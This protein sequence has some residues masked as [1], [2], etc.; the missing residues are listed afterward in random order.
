MNMRMAFYAFATCLSLAT[1]AQAEQRLKGALVP[2]E[3]TTLPPQ[4]VAQAAPPQQQVQQTPQAPAS[5]SDL[6]NMYQGYKADTQTALDRPH[7]SHA[8]L[9]RWLTE[10]LAALF[11]FTPGQV[12]QELQVNRAIFTDVGYQN[13][14]ALLGQMPFGAGLRAQ[15]VK[16]M[17]VVNAEPLLI[18]QGSSAG[19]Y[20]WAFELPL[21]ITYTT[22]GNSV[23]EH[24]ALTLR[25]QMGRA[26]KGDPV[27]GV[28]I[29]TIA[30]YTEPRAEAGGQAATAP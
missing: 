18:G 14:L 19:R 28:L 1:S 2:V 10:K 20:A 27:N 30:E 9:S 29:E 26:A 24:K 4:R 16:V 15:N 8:E 17:A 25:L 12:A 13:Y 6:Q 7:R 5:A 21:L 23:S 11:T 3:A 22:Q